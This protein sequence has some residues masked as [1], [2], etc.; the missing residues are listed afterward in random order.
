LIINSQVNGCNLGAVD[1]TDCGSGHHIVIRG[2]TESGPG[3]VGTAPA[4]NKVDRVIGGIGRVTYTLQTAAS[5][6]GLIAVRRA[7]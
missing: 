2:Y 7:S 1:F 6:G 4:G 5:A 3:K